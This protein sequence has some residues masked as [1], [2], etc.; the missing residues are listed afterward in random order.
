MKERRGATLVGE[1][2]RDLVSG[3]LPRQIWRLEREAWLA[4][5]GSWIGLAPSIARPTYLTSFIFDPS[6]H[7]RR[8]AYE[9]E[10][11]AVRK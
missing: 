11:E 2:M 10:T 5:R 8:A 6:C 1:E 9:M 7:L 4:R 3:R